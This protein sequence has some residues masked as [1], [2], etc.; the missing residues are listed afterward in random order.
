[1]KLLSRFAFLALLFLLPFT[2][3][4][5][6]V[7]YFTPLNPSNSSSKPVSHAAF[8]A[9]LKKYV[10]AQGM[11]NYSGLR[12]DSA[13][14]NGYLKTV[15]D[16]L[17]NN[18]WSKQDQLA[19]WLNAYNAFTL[20]RVLRAYPL[21]SI[22]DLGGD[23]TLVNTVWDQKFIRLGKDKYTLNDIEQRIIRRH[24]DDYR[25]HFALVCAAMSCP[26]LRREA[27]V[28]SRLNQQLDEQGVDF[29]NDPTKN[30]LMNS[31]AE[32]S[33][34][35][36]FYP[37]DFKKDGNSIQKTIN[38]YAKQKISPEASLTYMNY[39]WALNEQK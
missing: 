36:N 24:F 20:Q 8:D 3:G 25:V 4:C 17:P 9:L 12:A 18:T 27:Y 15:S 11:V 37:G 13:A 22:K 39:N 26:K 21:K 5:Q 30:K 33:S 34:I 23:K 29:V 16:N 38:R 19:Y 31:K 6:Y 7:R 1:M 28:A 14:L 32:I 2:G 10:D 35:F